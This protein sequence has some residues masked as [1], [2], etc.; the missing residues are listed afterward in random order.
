MWQTIKNIFNLGVKELL[1][2]GHDTLM[3]ILIIYAFSL[4]VISVGTAQEESVTNAAIAIVDEDSS[5]LTSKLSGVFFLPMF[6]PAEYI[7]R[8][9]MDFLMDQGKYTFVVDF[10]DNFEKDLMAGKAPAI[11]LNV[12]ATRMS[13]AFVG[14]G[15]IQQILMTEIQRHVNGL[16]DAEK[17]QGAGTANI[18][19]RNRYNANLMLGWF[20]AVMQLVNSATML[21][22]ILTGAAL[23]K[24]REN[25]TLEHLMVMPVTPFE[26][27]VSKIWSMM[28]IVL[29]ATAASMIFVI[30]MTLKIPT[31]G[32]FW[33]YM[34]GMALHLF[35]VTSMGI[36]LACIA[37]SM[38]QLG[39]L[40]ILL[41]L[42]MQM[43]SGAST[44]MES[45][46]KIVQNI[47]QISPNTHCVS[48]SQAIL[49]RGADLSVVW[50]QFLKL[51]IIGLVLFIGSL[52]KFRK[53][54]AS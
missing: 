43:L 20:S 17:N 5:Q 37:K 10:P 15:Y 50:I 8:D 30:N 54:V 26:I 45:M 4:D 39:M 1:T 40:V 22:I 41:L 53:S 46:P 16:G 14:A 52:T 32:S 31:S 19:I 11:Q 51:F 21:A 28:L 7:N 6:K 48:F 12:D 42:P 36:Y 38:P 24:E 25:G 49:F 34:M 35:A 33:L 47:M 23:I 44:P 27:M 2:V 18:V 29:V 9:E 13:Q 3:V